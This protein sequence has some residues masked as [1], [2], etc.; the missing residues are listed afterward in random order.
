MRNSKM[1]SD[2]EIIIAFLYKRSGKEEL[3]YSNL[4]LNLS[5]DLKWFTPEDAKAFVNMSIKQKLLIKKGDLIK[6]SFD[7]NHIVVPVGFIPSKNIF[8][9]KEVEAIKDEDLLEKIVRQIVEKTKLEEK[10]VIGKIEDIANE[11][12]LTKEVA[13]LLFG[14]NYNILFQEFYEQIEGKIV[15]G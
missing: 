5:M 1:T 3:S 7:I 13:A 6:P 9:K 15:E 10:K 2:T 12:N 4:Y 11:R 14:K 8:E